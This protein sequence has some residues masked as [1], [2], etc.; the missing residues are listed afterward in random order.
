MRSMQDLEQE[1]IKLRSDYYLQPTHSKVVL[2]TGIP[3]EA[4]YSKRDGSRS[5][6]GQSQLS[7][8]GIRLLQECRELQNSD[9]QGDNCQISLSPSS[10]RTQS[11]TKAPSV[12]YQSTAKPLKKTL[13]PGSKRWNAFNFLLQVTTKERSNETNSSLYNQFTKIITPLPVCYHPFQ[14]SFFFSFL[15]F[16]TSFCFVFKYL[17]G[18]LWTIWISSLFFT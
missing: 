9:L 4:Q 3:S 18:I 5:Q 1:V 15:V 17:R 16:C 14:F 6:A 11:P 10:Q 8:A 12:G 7:F 2:L 13:S